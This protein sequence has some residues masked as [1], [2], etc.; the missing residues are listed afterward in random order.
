METVAEEEEPEEEGGGDGEAGEA[1]E[2]GESELAFAEAVAVA[3]TVEYVESAFADPY[4]Q[5][6]KLEVSAFH[7]PVWHRA[8]DS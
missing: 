3:P 8:Q 6:P 7:G 4:A 2:A 1:G 5:I